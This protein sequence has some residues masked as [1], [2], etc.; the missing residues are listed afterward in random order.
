MKGVR[1]VWTNLPQRQKKFEGIV[2]GRGLNLVGFWAF[3]KKT[4]EV[5]TK[6][7]VIRFCGGRK[8]SIEAD[9]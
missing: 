5:T 3:R 8:C 9:D 7:T 4:E 6:K 1:W 2:V